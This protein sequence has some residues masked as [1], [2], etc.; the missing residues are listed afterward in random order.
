MERNAIEQLKRI[1]EE[2]NFVVGRAGGE[3]SLCGEEERI[4]ISQL[5]SDRDELVVDTYFYSY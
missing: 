2:K 4:L 5:D 1:T 3:E